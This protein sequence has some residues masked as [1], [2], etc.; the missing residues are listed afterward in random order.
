MAGL[1]A[2]R[3][4]MQNPGGRFA[5]SARCRTRYFSGEQSLPTTRTVLTLIFFCDIAPPVVPAAD[6]APDELVSS[7]PVTSTR[8]PM[9]EA[10]R[11]DELPSSA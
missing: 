6:G 11:S 5:P 7:V 4:G 10:L 1:R 3:L 9:F 8:L 2:L